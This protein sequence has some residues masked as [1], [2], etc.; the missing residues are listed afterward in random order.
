MELAPLFTWRLSS[1]CGSVA[2]AEITVAQDIAAGSSVCIGIPMEIGIT[3]PVDGVKANQTSCT[4]ETYAISGAVGPTAIMDTEAVGAIMSAALDYV[5]QVAGGRTAIDLSFEIKMCIEVNS[6]IVLELPQFTRISNVTA[7]FDVSSNQATVFRTGMQRDESFSALRTD[8]CA[9]YT[10]S[11]II[12]FRAQDVIAADSLIKIRIPYAA[13]WALPEVG[14]QASSPNITIAVRGAACGDVHSVPI[15]QSPGVYRVG[16]FSEFG[17]RFS[18]KPAKPGTVSGIELR[19]HA[20][21]TLFQNDTF[22]IYMPGFAGNS[23]IVDLNSSVVSTAVWDSLTNVMSF[24]ISAT[25]ITNLFELF[26]PSTAGIKLPAQ[27][28]PTEGHG[29]EINATAQAGPVSRFGD[30][31]V[32]GIGSLLG[33]PVVKFSAIN[34]GQLTDVELQFTAQMDLMSGDTIVLVLDGFSGER[35]YGF[36]VTDCTPAGSI[37]EVTWIPSEGLTFIIN[38]TVPQSTP[39]VIRISQGDIPVFM[40]DDG[41][42]ANSPTLKLALNAENG[43]VMDHPIFN[44]G[45]GKILFS[46]LNFNH[47]VAGAVSGITVEIVPVRELVEG[48]FFSFSLPGFTGQTVTEQFVRSYPLF[49][50][51]YCDWVLETETLTFYVARTVTEGQSLKVF[52]P[53]YAGIRVPAAGIPAQP[54]F[55]VSSTASGG[56]ATA[57]SL[58]VVQVVGTVHGVSL[59][60]NHSVD[61]QIHDITLQFSPGVQIESGE[62][63]EL[64]ITQLQ[65]P[66]QTKCTPVFSVPPSTFLTADWKEESRAIVLLVADDVNAHQKVSFTIPTGAMMRFEDG[67]DFSSVQV[68]LTINAA[69]G[70]VFNFPV[71]IQGSV[72]AVVLT[73][74]S[75]HLQDRDV[76]SSSLQFVDQ[77]AGKVSAMDLTV[78]IS[79]AIQSGEHIQVKLFG[80]EGSDGKFS[81]TSIPND[82][83]VDGNWTFRTYTQENEFTEIERIQLQESE[84]RHGVLGFVNYT[85]T[86]TREVNQTFNDTFPEY[87]NVTLYKNVTSLKNVSQDEVYSWMEEVAEPNALTQ[88]CEVKSIR[89]NGIRAA[90]IVQNVSDVVAYTQVV[91]VQSWILRHELVN[92]TSTEICRNAE[93]RTILFNRTFSQNQS[94]LLRGFDTLMLTFD[95]SYSYPCKY[96][97][98]H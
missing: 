95:S 49:Q 44:V 20:I 41:L 7:S 19:I 8:L 35:R 27:G 81:V 9:R 64:V 5:I 63:I 48:D 89:Q 31:Q 96:N 90:Y 42:P 79:V 66:I 46:S 91:R 93:N 83:F 86:V 58:S 6:S 72:T 18:P 71:S 76:I 60:V 77:S 2:C 37:A 43:D 17:F 30:V 51:L 85:C 14:I 55:T 22:N 24:K 80:F 57:T 54:G 61:G 15:P 67:F 45:I 52:V 98:T 59:N 26:V 73:E 33:M 68:H 62:S 13:G 82:A 1:S 87:K 56:S 78:N 34:P 47:L 65:S 21:M 50:V 84:I 88:K 11:P 38:M 69:A 23:T 97:S 4:I 32:G 94:N 39:V 16:G 28:V 25:K 92:L 70:P 36:P 74:S 75:L 53:E 12:E 10:R 40:P 29:I 3:L